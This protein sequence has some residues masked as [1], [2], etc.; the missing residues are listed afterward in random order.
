MKPGRNDPCPCGSGNKYKHCCLGSQSALHAQVQDDVANIIALNPGLTLDELNVVVQ[1]NMHARNHQ[2]LADFCGLSPSQMSNWLD[3]PFTALNEVQIHT[4]TELSASPVMCYLQLMVDAA[5]QNGG[6]FKATS[7][8]NLPTVIVKQ[9]TD[10]LPQFAVAAL[11]GDLSISEFAGSNEDKFNALHYTRVLAEIA[12]IFYRRSGSYHLKKTAQKA[13]LSQGIGAFFQPMLEAA[14]SQYNWGY[15]DAIEQPVDIRTFW[16]FMLWR[17]QSHADLERLTDEVATAFPDLMRQ[18][19]PTEYT[20]PLEML[21]RLITLRF[22]E[23]FLQ[24][25]GFVTLDRRRVYQQ[26]AGPD[27]V[28]RQP[29]LTATF[30]FEIS[31]AKPAN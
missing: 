1:R 21:K 30:L 29:L 25:W 9:A 12:G 24:F 26:P 20:E 19:I 4:P 22:V 3:A 5:L 7:K 23:R 11:Q 31:E 15:L 10:L 28:Q 18:L 2:P 17:L 13:Y 27:M 14:V 16:L 6:S 8:G